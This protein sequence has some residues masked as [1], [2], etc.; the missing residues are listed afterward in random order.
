[1]GLGIS[2]LVLMVV[3]NLGAECILVLVLVFWLCSGLVMGIL[4]R[5]R[6]LGIVVLKRR[7]SFVRG[8]GI[9]WVLCS[10]VYY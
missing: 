8:G 5:E 2:T 4:R 6:Y 10:Q 7:W 3:I 1:M 9:L